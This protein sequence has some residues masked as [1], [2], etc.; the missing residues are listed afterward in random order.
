VNIVM[1]QKEEK[2]KRNFMLVFEDWN[3]LKNTPVIGKKYSIV[4]QGKKYYDKLVAVYSPPIFSDALESI[5]LS[6]LVMESARFPTAYALPISFENPIPFKYVHFD[7]DQ[8]PKDYLIVLERSPEVNINIISASSEVPG[9]TPTERM[10][11][12]SY[13]Q[14]KEDSR[15]VKYLTYKPN[16]KK[17]PNSKTPK[18]DTE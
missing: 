4:F 14:L 18:K 13:L 3:K 10:N 8:T 16:S 12:L 7:R 15:T 9:P 11:I 17:P 2:M 6:D 5:I 1:N